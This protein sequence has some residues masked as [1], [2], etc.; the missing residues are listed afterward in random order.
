MDLDADTKRYIV[1]N[2]SR[3]FS[4]EISQNG[5]VNKVRIEGPIDIIWT[6][7]KLN[8]NTFKREIGKSTIYVTEGRVVVKEKQLSAK[9]FQKVQVDKELV[10]DETFMV[11]DIESA[12]IDNEFVPFLV[13]AYNPKNFIYSMSESIVNS[14][15]EQHQL[16]RN[17]LIQL[18]MIKGLKYVYAHNLSGFDGIFLLRHLVKI[19]GAKTEPLLHNGKLICI[20][21]TYTDGNKTK[22]ITFKDSLLLLPLSLRDLCTAFKVRTP[23][24][25]FPF[26]LKTLST[27]YVSE[28]FPSRDL[29]PNISKS[30]YIALKREHGNKVWNFK[31]EAIKYCKTDCVALFEVLKIFN[32]YVFEAFELNPHKSLTLSSLAMRIF[33]ANYMPKN[34]LFKILGKVEEDIK[35]SYTGVPAG[36]VDVYIPTN[37]YSDNYGKTKYETL[38]NYDKNSLYPTGMVLFDMPTGK[39]IAFEG[40]IRKVDPNAYGFFYCKITT[41]DYLEH[42]ILQR[43]IKTKDGMRTIAGLGSWEG[44]IASI[45]MDNAAEKFNYKFEI[46]RGYKFEPKK[47]FE[48]FVV[49]LY[50]IKM[51]YPKDHPLYIISK[52]L[53]NS[54]YG[55]FGMSSQTTVLD[56]VD[57]T[58]GNRIG[59]LLDKYGESIQD[60]L[61]LDT[62]HTIILRKN[63]EN[64]Y[65]D[66]LDI[67]PYHGLDVNVGVASAI[68]AGGRVL[69]SFIFNNPDYRLYYTDTD[70]MVI[71]R[72][73]PD[74]LVGPQLGLF[75]L[76]HVIE[77]AVF[78]APKVYALVTKNDG[79]EIIKIKGVT[80]NAIQKE[81]IS[82]AILE[83][84]LH[85]NLGVRID[86]EKWFKDIANG[87]ITTTMNTYNLKATANKRELIYNENY[88]I[89]TKPYNY[90][91][92]E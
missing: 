45:E 61:K 25:Y 29:Y 53:M 48:E 81:R 44:W 55:K 6:D 51:E 1:R 31:D 74:H 28:T 16:F 20:K 73:L 7:T 34:T 89:G 78:L 72:P 70:S 92:L 18:V 21:F 15:S 49:K 64:F 66:D 77:R 47:I 4:I 82:Y 23:K 26:D 46:I 10:S 79:K 83:N 65:L 24:S 56:V 33:K 76:E 75:K 22:V 85:V 43:R 58:E 59:D 69:M 71:N 88:L 62:D 13:C 84:I 2:D 67:D 41:P 27:S 40:D 36:A 8:E 91:D 39:P 87:R 37:A 68:A 42:P 14:Q 5:L 63:L 12:N 54:I 19:Q 3:V 38:F 52:L 9:P 35:E 90:Q 60:I 80:K 86:Q 50:S 17:F 57:T 32:Q 11:M 30:D